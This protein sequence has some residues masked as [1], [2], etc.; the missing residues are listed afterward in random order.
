M[1]CILLALVVAA[2]P[3]YG[4]ESAL[5]AGIAASAGTTVCAALPWDGIGADV[6]LVFAQRPQRR[7]IGRILKAA[8]TCEPLQ[9]ADVPPPYFALDASAGPA[10]VPWLAIALPGDI[11]VSDADGMLT[12]EL[13]RRS[14]RESFS[15]CTSR[16]GVHLRIWSGEPQSGVERWHAYIYAG[17]DLE[18]TCP[19]QRSEKQ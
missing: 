8:E 6:T 1:K 11:A 19:R 18:P 15:E 17:V 14:P 9:A 10:D 5:V 16:D 2:A 13:D 12:A 3:A 7:V 4:A